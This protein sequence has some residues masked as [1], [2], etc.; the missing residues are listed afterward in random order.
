M[1][2]FTTMFERDTKTFDAIGCCFLDRLLPLLLRRR[3]NYHGYPVTRFTAEADRCMARLTKLFLLN[4]QK[5][6]NMNCLSNAFG[7]REI[8]G[9]C[10]IAREHPSRVSAKDAQCILTML[11]EM[12]F[13]A[14]DP[15]DEW[16]KR[17]AQ[18]AKDKMVRSLCEGRIILTQAQKE[19]NRFAL[20]KRMAD[21]KAAKA[22]KED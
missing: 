18:R 4:C 7:G 13:A 6:G 16:E 2:L 21:A 10:A 9:I 5:G 17:H 14:N 19:D 15:D 12:N 20:K 22:A 11:E 8:Q 1:K 3:A